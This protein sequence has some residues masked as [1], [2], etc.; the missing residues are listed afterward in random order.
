MQVTGNGGSITTS[1]QGHLKKYGDVWFDERAI[2]NILFLNNTKN[3]YPVTYDSAENGNFTVHKT[4]EVSSHDQ[5]PCSHEWN[6][7]DVHDVNT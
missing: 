5:G 4:D 7:V 6:S 3:K 2:T 1:K